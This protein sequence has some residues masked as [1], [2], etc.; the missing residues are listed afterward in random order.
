MTRDKFKKMLPPTSKN[1]LTGVFDVLVAIGYQLCDVE[2]T[3]IAWLAEIAKVVKK[4][5][6]PVPFPVLDEG[7]PNATGADDDVNVNME[8]VL[9]LDAGIAAIKAEQVELHAQLTK[10]GAAAKGAQ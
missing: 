8:T 3:N 10:M 1:N 5:P 9:R 2:E 4:G 6:D 7:K